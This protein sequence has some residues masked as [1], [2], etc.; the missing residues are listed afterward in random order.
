MFLHESAPQ[1]HG[2]AGVAMNEAVLERSPLHVKAMV[3]A[4]RMI[5]AILCLV[6][7]TVASRLALR[8]F[9]KPPRSPERR[10]QKWVAEPPRVRRVSLEAR[11]IDI[12]EFGHGARAVLLVHGWGGR[13][14]DLAAFAQPLLDRGFRVAW[15]DGPAHG[16]SS[17]QA[18]D[19]FQFAA[20]I[21]QVCRTVPGVEA[22]VAHSFGAACSLLANWETPLGVRRMVL[23]G[24]FAD[25]IYITESFGRF[26]RIAPAVT[27]GM[28]SL[29]AERYRR[30]WSWEEIAPL[31]LVKCARL[32]ILFIHDADDDEVPFAQAGALADAAESARL[33][34]TQGQ[35]HRRILRDAAAVQ[36]ATHFV[37]DALGAEDRSA[38]GS[39]LAAREASAPDAARAS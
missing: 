17:G 11:E 38:S 22:I 33:Y 2:H 36:A 3:R 5:F 31:R 9:L 1:E 20:A 37:C 18:T 19:M 29:L 21:R 10:W 15:F 34:R 16:S 25:A 24:C 23:V 13:G 32:P 26:L 8:L 35:G 27:A 4:L 14:S 28:R 7:R 39:V 6:S 12:T 30:R